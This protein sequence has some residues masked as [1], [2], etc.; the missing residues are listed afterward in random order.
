M[1]ITIGCGPGP[2]FVTASSTTPGVTYFWTDE[3]GVTSTEQNPEVFGDGASMNT[4]TITLVVTAPNGCSTTTSVTVIEDTTPPDVT[5]TGTTIDCRPGPFFITASSTTPGVTY[6]WTD[7]NGV[8]STEQNPEVFGDGGTMNTTTITLVVTAPN[9]C[10][11][12]TSVTVIEDTTPPDVTAMGGTITCINTSV[13]LMANST[14]PGV[15]Y[16]WTDPNGLT[17]S[18]QNPTDI[19]LAGTYTVVV[20]ASNSCTAMTTVTVIDDTTPPDLTAT[21]G[22]INCINSS[23][24]LMANSTTPGVTYLW[25]DPN[26]TNTTEQNPADIILVGTYTVVATAPNGCTATATVMV[27]EDITPPDVTATG[28]TITCANPFITLMASSVITGVTYRWTYPNGLNST[29]QNPLASLLGTYIVEVTAPSGCIAMTTV[30]VIDGT[31]VAPMSSFTFSDNELMVS[32]MDNST[33]MPTSW[34][35]NFGDGNTATDQSPTYNYL[36]PGTYTVCLTARNDCGENTTCET[37]SVTTSATDV[38]TFSVGSATGQ[39]GTIIQIPVSVQYFTNIVSFQKS[40]HVADPTAARLVGVSDFNLAGLDITDFNLASGDTLTVAWFNEGGVSVPDGTVIYMLNIE[41]LTSFEECTSVFIDGNPTIIEAADLDVDGSISAVPYLIKSGE[42]CVLPKVDILGS[43]FRENGVVLEDVIVEC[44]TAPATIT[45]A[46][47]EYEFLN[48][49]SGLDYTVIPTRNT[50]HRDGVT[51][52]DLALIQRHILNVQLLNSPYKMIAADVDIS[53]LVSGIDLVKMQQLI[54]NI[55]TEFPDFNSWRFVDEK[56]LFTDPANPFLDNFPED[57]E[58][59]NLG[60]DTFGNDFIAMKLGDVNESAIGLQA[61]DGGEMNMLIA[62]T[63]NSDGSRV[64]EFRSAE[65]TTLSAYQFD[66]QFDY[67]QMSLLEVIPGALPGLNSTFFG[68]DNVEEGLITTL[69][70]DPSAT[71]GGW[72]LEQ[73]EVLFS[74]RF[75]APAVVAAIEDRIQAGVATMKSAGYKHNGDALKIKTNYQSLATGVEGLS[76]DQLISQLSVFPNPFQDKASISFTLATASTIN[77]QVYD[78]TGKV[79]KTIQ[80]YLGAGA[81]Q[82]SISA[83][84]LNGIGGLYLVKLQ[85]G[86]YVVTRKIMFQK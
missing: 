38:L 60:Q 34:F 15:T 50:D 32:F 66:I 1:G 44:T 86:D 71:E 84:D 53:G 16:L 36:A 75:E 52:I 55:T 19:S 17:S 10:S 23:V 41:L 69:W 27:I 56:F 85:T 2:F 39:S 40:I 78:A 9:G 13:T 82:I 67:S 21:G 76:S 68:M 37:V 14:T 64:I 31:E 29:E 83:N 26:G 43:I 24:T 8:T 73:D 12:T 20:T 48:L 22:T 51:A 4:T 62:E 63:V 74:L 5:A 42:A 77:V 7:E 6:F 70:Y 61:P 28:G 65:N 3:N 35:W 33:N 81:Q 57:I 79:V 25:T 58:F 11:T 49:G 45:D 46:F 72:E 80:Q 59:M 18:E 47:G 30:T 54:L